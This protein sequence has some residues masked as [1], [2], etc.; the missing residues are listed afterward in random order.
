MIIAKELTEATGNAKPLSPE[1]KIQLEAW[2]YMQELK[3]RSD[4][5]C[6]DWYDV[7]HAFEAGAMKARGL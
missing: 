4:S 2:Q 1:E 7:M 6:P 5:D 3:M